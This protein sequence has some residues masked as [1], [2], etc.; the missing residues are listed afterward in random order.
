MI[1][2]VDSFKTS[3]TAARVAIYFV[4]TR[5]TIHAGGTDTFANVYKKSEC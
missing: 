2:T 5:G 3:W 4:E 1:F